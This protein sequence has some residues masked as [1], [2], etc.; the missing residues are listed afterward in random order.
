MSAGSEELNKVEKEEKKAENKQL[1][2]N[3]AKATKL[4]LLYKK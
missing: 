3:L 2:K 1:L 4:L